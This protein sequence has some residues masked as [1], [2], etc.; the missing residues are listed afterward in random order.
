MVLRDPREGLLTI[1]SQPALTFNAEAK[2]KAREC[3]QSRSAR[4]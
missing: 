2:N 3:Y 1:L 4:D